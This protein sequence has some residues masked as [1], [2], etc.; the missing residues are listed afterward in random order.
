M[1]WTFCPA[2]GQSW[3]NVKEA[4]PCGHNL[5]ID[6][7]VDN[8]GLFPM[9][10]ADLAVSKIVEELGE[11]ADAQIGISGIN[12]RKGVYATTY[13]LRKEL[14]DVALTALIAFIKNGGDGNPTSALLAHA[15]ERAARHREQVG[16]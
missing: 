8:A 14:L 12:L 2:C 5:S 10:T 13:D 4:L 11:V 3:E 15:R 1:S 16:V 9:M 6:P 7:I